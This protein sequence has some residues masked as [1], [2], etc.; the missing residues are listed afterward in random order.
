MYD[1]PTRKLIR[2]VHA[3]FA[4]LDHRVFQVGKYTF[5]TSSVDMKPSPENTLKLDKT[6]V[7]VR[8]TQGSKSSRTIVGVIKIRVVAGNVETCVVDYNSGNMHVGEAPA[9]ITQFAKVTLTHVMDYA[10]ANPHHIKYGLTSKAS[11][12][13][14]QF[15]K[16]MGGKK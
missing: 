2:A 6:A 15:S 12:M 5:E 4:G 3:R 11:Q 14:K 16:K 13:M 10:N 9:V 7:W 1:D 8:V